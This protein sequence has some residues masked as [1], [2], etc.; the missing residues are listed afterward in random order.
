MK[1]PEM[2][3]QPPERLAI[4]KTAQTKSRASQLKKGQLASY[5]RRLTNCAIRKILQRPP[6]AP[7][8]GPVQPHER[9]P[10]E[11]DQDAGGRLQPRPH[12]SANVTRAR[13]GRCASEPEK[14][15]RH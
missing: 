11:L 10:A 9:E 5:S 1:Q 12:F 13:A 7:P 4:R 2:E 6:K 15:T 8:L 3:K 14:P